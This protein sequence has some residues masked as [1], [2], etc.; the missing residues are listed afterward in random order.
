MFI[1]ADNLKEEALEEALNKVRAEIKKVGGVVENTTRM[2]RKQFARV[3]DKKDAGQYVL[4]TFSSGGEHISPLLAKYQLN[5]EVFRV[6]IMRASATP[7]PAA[8]AAEA[9]ETK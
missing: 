7:P 4:I 9:P 8:K 5:E 1:F 6:T 3:L 2:G